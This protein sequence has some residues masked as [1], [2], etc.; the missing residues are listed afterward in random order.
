MNKLLILIA[1]LIAYCCFKD[2]ITEMIPGQNK[3]KK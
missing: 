1:V 2:K 3:D